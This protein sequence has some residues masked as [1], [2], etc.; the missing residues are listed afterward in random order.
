[1]DTDPFKILIE[2]EQIQN[3][4][5]TNLNNISCIYF[6]YLKGIYKISSLS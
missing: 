1:M 5:S 3:Y 6:I 4:K 2:I